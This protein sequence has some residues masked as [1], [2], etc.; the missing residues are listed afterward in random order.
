MSAALREALAAWDAEHFMEHAI[1]LGDEV[2]NYLADSATAAPEPPVIKVRVRN[3]PELEVT[4]WY[5]DTV[6]IATP[7]T[8][9][10][11]AP[12]AGSGEALQAPPRL[13]ALEIHERVRPFIH[14]NGSH[15]MPDYRGIWEAAAKWALAASTTA[16]GST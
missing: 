15:E 16:E 13:T 4:G 5:G 9:A 11:P 1:W 14:M 10:E 8:P 7:P 6:Y 12:P 2:R 3:G